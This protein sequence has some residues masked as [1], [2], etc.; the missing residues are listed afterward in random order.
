MADSMILT[1]QGIP[2]FQAGQEFLR[3]KGGDDNSYKSNDTVNKID[4]TRKS[5]N[6]DTVNYFKGLIKLR[7]SHPA[8]R[9]TSADMIKKNLKFL[10]S[11]QKMW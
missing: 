4:W 5:E 11:Y 1:S 9:M 2:F 3:T 6:I 10:N 8:F 7:K